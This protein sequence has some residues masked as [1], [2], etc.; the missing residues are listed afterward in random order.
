MNVCHLVFVP[1]SLTYMVTKAAVSA[2]HTVYIC[3]SDPEH[4]QKAP[5]K[6]MQRLMKLPHVIFITEENKAALP[7]R[8][9]RLI[10][11]IFPRPT[12][13]L[14]SAMLGEMAARSRKITLVTAGDRS[15]FRRTALQMQWRELCR[16]VRWLGR[17]D[18]VVYK[19]GF[20]PLDLFAFFKPRRVTGFD[21]HSMFM[22]DEDAFERIQKL[23]WNVEETRPIS[24]NFMG[25]QDPAIR[26]RALDSIRPEII[27]LQTTTAPMPSPKTI[28]WHEYS[29]TEPAALGLQE[30]VDALSR[31]DFTLCPPGYSLITHRPI[32]AMLRG[33][34]PVLHANE[35]GLYDIALTDG[36]NCIAVSEENWPAALERC[37]HLNEDAIVAMRRNV[38]ET[39]EALLLY[40]TSSKRMRLRLGFTT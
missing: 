17:V 11:Q 33:S 39:A 9:D 22:H 26:K 21:I 12:A 24:I 5:H 1:D 31:S 20:H 8:I 10:V 19:D 28:L 18:R 6:I 4:G 25:S 32:E 13:T 23:D 40:P 7:A 27:R 15:R 29:D 14:E 30:F 2:G 37:A 34:I 38:R 35:L 16:L 36:V 3:L